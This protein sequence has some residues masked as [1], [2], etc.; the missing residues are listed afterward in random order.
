M[1][2]PDLAGFRD[3]QQRLV[4]NF[5]INVTFTFPTSSAIYSSATYI[6]PQTSRPLDPLIEPYAEYVP[7]ASTVRAT[8]IRRVPTSFNEGKS[9]RGGIVPE[10][11]LW[12]RIPDG[13]YTNEIF[14]ASE[15]IIGTERYRVDRLAR[16]GI[17]DY[18]RVYVEL[19]LI[20]DS[21]TSSPPA[22]SV[23]IAGDE[24]TEYFES[25]DGQTT[26]NLSYPYIPGTTFVT[27]DGVGQ[28]EGVGFD[29]LE[30]PP[31]QIIFF[32]PLSPGQNIIVLY[33]VSA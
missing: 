15:A 31:M 17:H 28:T 19:E 22:S 27:V 11:K 30:N 29:Y 20:R 26:F 2:T 8:V 18:D 9:S 13:M 25:E 24:I 23:V 12:L 32:T 10:G 4:S 33:E 7:L 21:F 14:A 1:N 5:G 3:A 16:D 6:D